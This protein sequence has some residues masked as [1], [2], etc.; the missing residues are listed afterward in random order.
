MSLRAFWERLIRGSRWSWVDDRYR[1]ALPADFDAS[2]MTI[3]SRDR[4]H[5]KQGRSTARVVFHA[6]E[7]RRVSVY[8]KRHFRLPW[9]ARLAATF[10]P[11]GRHSPGAAEWAH[12]ERA[13]ALG[14]PVPDVVAVGERVGPW[15]A[16]QSYLAVAELPGRELNEV[17]PDLERSLDPESFAAMKRRIV[18]EM[19]RIAATMHRARVFHKDLYL[20]HFFVNLEKLARDPRDVELTLI[21]LHRL[22]EHRLTADRWRWKDL[23]QLLFSMEG[24]AGV[25]PRDALR[26][27]KHYRKAAGLHRP[28]WQ[29]TMIRLKAA[30]Y[31]A[32]N[33]G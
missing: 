21:D 32:H 15:G 1:E 22:R 18:R 33:Q 25:A 23:G 31:A 20:C 30:R 16:L 4:L 8:L 12:L 24:V 14:V 6:P 13:R 2:V 10:N 7:G 9:P 19:A 3:V 27:W 26:F 29:A 17:L 11:A 28:E 5:A